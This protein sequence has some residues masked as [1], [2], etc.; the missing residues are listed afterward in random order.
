M[1][2]GEKGENGTEKEEVGNTASKKGPSLVNAMVKIRYGNGAVLAHVVRR[3]QELLSHFLARREKAAE[4]SASANGGRR[5]EG[6]H[7]EDID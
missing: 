3:R 5:D 2:E 6:A 1:G 4:G 7:F